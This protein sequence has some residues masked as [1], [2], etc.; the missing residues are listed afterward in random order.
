M[1]DIKNLNKNYGK[2]IEKCKM[3]LNTTSKMQKIMN[4]ILK[5]YNIV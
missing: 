3:K 1:K 4:Q 5:I 2:L